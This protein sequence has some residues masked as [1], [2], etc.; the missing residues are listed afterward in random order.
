[1]P[2]QPLKNSLP[3][4]S[5]LSTSGPRPMHLDM[6]HGRIRIRTAQASDAVESMANWLSEPAVMAGLNGDG[7]TMTVPMLSGYIAG[8]DNVRK[9]LAVIHDTRNDTPIGILMFEIEPRHK[10][11]SFHILIGERKNWLPERAYCAVRLIL[12][13]MFEK[14][15]MEKVSIEPLSRNHLVVRICHRFGFRLEG[16]LLGHRA[17]SKTGDR[18]D[19]HIFG[20]TRNEYMAW[21]HRLA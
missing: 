18:L 6:V 13:H 8:F 7:R 17:D 14:R 3:L 19:Q 4:R 21:P 16:V 2:K 1:M 12:K 10:I 11:G 20:M 15:G 9:N 5:V